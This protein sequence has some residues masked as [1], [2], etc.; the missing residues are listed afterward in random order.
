M[1]GAKVFV[2]VGGERQAIRQ[3]TADDDDIVQLAGFWQIDCGSHLHAATRLDSA[4]TRSNHAPLTMDL[5][6]PVGLVGGMSQTVDETGEGD[7]RE[8]RRKDEPNP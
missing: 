2:S 4:S 6:A 1:R 8:L 3:K 7:E 5:A